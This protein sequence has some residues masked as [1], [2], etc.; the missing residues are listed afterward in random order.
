VKTVSSAVLRHPVVRTIAFS[1]AL[2]L[3]STGALAAGAQLPSTANPAALTRGPGIDVGRTFYVAPTGNDAANGLTLET[4]FR[5]IEHALEVVQPGDTIQLRG[6]TYVPIRNVGLYISRGGTSSAW[7][8]IKAFNGERAVIDARGKEAGM[9]FGETAPFWIVEGLEVV[10][11]NYAIQI[12]SPAVRLVS[13][14][15]YG[16]RDDIVKLTRTASDSAIYGN[17][18]HHNTPDPSNPEPNSQG[19]DMVG[20]DRVWIAYN[21]VHDIPSIGMYTKGGSHGVLFEN[22]RVENV[23][24]DGIRLGQATGPEF[25]NQQPYESYD[26]V[27]RNNFVVNSGLACLATSSSYN[28]K[29]YGNTCQNAAMTG[30]GAIFVSN[31]SMLGQAGTNVDIKDN[32]VIVS[33]QS[34]RPIVKLAPNAMTDYRTLHIDNNRYWSPNGANAVTFTMEDRSLW[35]VP[36]GAWR[37]VAG[38]DAHSVIAAP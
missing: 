10:G 29:I 36:V 1:S 23:R 31:E 9:Y 17:E 11:G 35:T 33:T 2:A 25:M 7:K 28:A 27:I 4:P 21:Y 37:D 13:N 14:S 22:N 12:D 34:A 18:I 5:S 3:I 20:A 24:G 15:L 32:V 19:I 8:K 16:S 6:G 26:G 30:Q 38:Q